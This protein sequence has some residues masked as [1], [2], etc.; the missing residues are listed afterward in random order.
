M[1]WTFKKSNLGA[2]FR[3]NWKKRLDTV[4]AVKRLL[5][6]SRYNVIRKERREKKGGVI[7][8]KMAK[9]RQQGI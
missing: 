5:Q 1:E 8:R 7:C 2:L 6:P 9:G 3:L 4:K